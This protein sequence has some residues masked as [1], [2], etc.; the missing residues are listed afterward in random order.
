MTTLETHQT[1]KNH[2]GEFICFRTPLS[3]E[4]LSL[5]YYGT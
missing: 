2:T 4:E 1:L 3:L 5:L